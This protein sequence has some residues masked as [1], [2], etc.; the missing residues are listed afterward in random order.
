M[1][2]IK[3]APEPQLGLGALVV[4]IKVEAGRSHPVIAL[5]RVAMPLSELR[6]TLSK[7]FAPGSADHSVF[8]K[9]SR[10]VTYADLI[11][12]MDQ[13]KGAG[14]DYISLLIDEVEVPRGIPRPLQHPPDV[15]TTDELTGVPGGVLPGGEPGPPKIIRKSGGVLKDSAIRRV[16]AATP[17]LARAAKVS[18]PVVVEVTIDEEGDVISVRALSG[19]PLLKDAAV[20]AARGW[21]F[22]RTELSGVP[23]KVIG[24]LTFVFKE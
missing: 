1:R 4:E 8:T 20:E 17:P 18:G 16:E 10:D 3:V 2:P 21:K 22:S 15:A 24:T 12:I 11:T 7:F 5:N 13:I 23:V 6:S 19:H 9:P 14:A